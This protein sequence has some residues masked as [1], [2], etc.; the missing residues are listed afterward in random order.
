[1]IACASANRR[2]RRALGTGDNGLSKQIPLFFQLPVGMSTIL[3]SYPLPPMAGPFVRRHLGEF[4]SRQ[5]LL[6]LP[7]VA[8]IGE[9]PQDPPCDDHPVHLVGA[10]VDA[11]GAGVA[12]HALERRV[13][14]DAAGAVDLDRAVDDVMQDLRAP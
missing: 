8:A 6:K 10:V 12:V 11:G 14:G 9:R 1:P 3:Q 13:A 4:V 5:Y 7:A 2:T